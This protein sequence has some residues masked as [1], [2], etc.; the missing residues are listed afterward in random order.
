MATK[1]KIKIE[2]D[3]TE[4]IAMFKKMDAASKAT[5]EDIIKNNKKS[6]K[7]FKVL[8]SAIQAALASTMITAGAAAIKK[9][10]SLGISFEILRSKS[11]EAADTLERT[12]D[13]TFGL[14]N[15]FEMVA[16]TN[17]AL[18]FGFDL[19]GQKLDKLM[20]MSAKTAMVMGTSVEKTFDDLVTGIARGS[21][22][23]LDNLGIMVDITQINQNY[24]DAIGKNVEMLTE[25][26]KIS[27]LTD[28]V[29]KKLA[30]STKAVSD[31]MVNSAMQGTKAIKQVE[32]AWTTALGWAAK[33]FVF[34]GDLAGKRHAMIMGY[35][36]RTPLERQYAE[37]AKTIEDIDK[38]GFSKWKKHQE[39]KVKAQ[40]ENLDQRTAL[41][42]KFKEDNEATDEEVRE[43]KKRLVAIEKK[44]EKKEYNEKLDLYFQYLKETEKGQ[45]WSFDRFEA[46]LKDDVAM[47]G[48]QLTKKLKMF[49]E[50]RAKDKQLREE[51]RDP[52]F[53]MEDLVMV[54]G[55]FIPKADFE[56]QKKVGETFQLNMDKTE[57][58]RAKNTTKA[59]N[60]RKQE[61]LDLLEA[62]KDLWKGM[63]EAHLEYVADIAA[64]NM[65]VL[66]AEFEA[67]SAITDLRQWEADNRAKIAKAE[68]KI[69]IDEA[70]KALKEKQKLMKEWGSIALN[71]GISG[72][73]DTI[74]NR[75]D[76][77]KAEKSAL[78]GVTGDSKEAEEERAKIRNEYAAA[79]EHEQKTWLQRMA[80][81]ALAGAGAKMIADGTQRIWVG[82]GEMIATGG[83]KGGAEVAWGIAEIGAGIGL[84]AVAE[85]GMPSG[86]D[87]DSSK[88][89]GSADRMDTQAAVDKQTKEELDIYLYPDEKQW[90][91]KLRKDNKK[92]GR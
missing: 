1:G 72:I 27:A 65:M 81:D 71:A 57:D 84:G 58:K 47:Y 10:E 34:L 91:E 50:Y 53:G 45:R 37:Y 52:E 38:L 39:D 55:R 78:D 87:I 54:G 30:V 56:H 80:M 70:K 61:W 28:E 83:I 90:L 59:N 69:E 62:G 89:E 41:L 6:G 22:M 74:K 49:A 67:Q 44:A 33:A 42:L 64:Q 20:K 32:T 21:K 79:R 19:S 12:S 63:K 4:V 11:S 16:A 31:E 36:T 88:P 7:S 66:G 85:A 51:A 92:I 5:S 76:L 26:E 8:G 25:Q 24:A 60:K 17:K 75:S 29:N 68:K 3:A 46:F 23:I 82:G 40:K 2:G 9:S 15:K 43:E 86:Y 48:E 77:R 73:Q 14:A 18:A 13:L 35:D